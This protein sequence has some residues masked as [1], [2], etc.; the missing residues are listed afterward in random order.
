MKNCPEMEALLNDHVDEL[1]SLPE[2]QRLNQHLGSCTAC[3]E[4]VESLKALRERTAEL[5]E[6]VQPPRDLWPAIQAAVLTERGA[7]CPLTP[8]R[9]VGPARKKPCRSMTAYQI[10]KVVAF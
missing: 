6:S 8:N 3:G 7:P 2:Q 9:D 1:L 5:P 10:S 4:A